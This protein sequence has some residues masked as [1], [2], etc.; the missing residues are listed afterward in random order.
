[1][2][3]RSIWCTSTWMRFV[4]IIR[5]QP[6]CY[7]IQPK[8]INIH[9]TMQRNKYW[10][11]LLVVVVFFFIRL[12][13]LYQCCHYCCCCNVF[14]VHVC[15]CLFVHSCVVT[16]QHEYRCLYLLG[17]FTFDCEFQKNHANYR[18]FLTS[19]TDNTKMTIN[20]ECQ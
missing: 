6:I 18:S 14:C 7:I 4:E 12:S 10:F 2:S 9:L 8:S 15:S 11:R 16:N 1:M 19:T 13:Q 3:L 5:G 20:Y 17:N